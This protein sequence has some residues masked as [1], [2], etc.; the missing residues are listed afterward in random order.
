RYPPIMVRVRVGLVRA[1]MVEAIIGGLAATAT[2]GIHI[3][4]VA[5]GTAVVG[6]IGKRR[7]ESVWVVWRI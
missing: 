4:A 3:G 1:T 7:S 2:T 6:I 5:I